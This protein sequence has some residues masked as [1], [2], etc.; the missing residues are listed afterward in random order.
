MSKIDPTIQEMIEDFKQYVDTT[1]R[2]SEERVKKEI[3]E[4]ISK[5]LDVKID[6]VRQEMSEGFG[7]V[8]DSVDRTQ[9]Q[10]D[11]HERRLTSLE[12]A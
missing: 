12:A 11:D 9:D 10:L 3:T 1:V 7:G 2:G 5:K 6:L 4:E 8:G